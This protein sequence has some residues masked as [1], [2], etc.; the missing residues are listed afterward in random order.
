MRTI[1]INKITFNHIE[2]HDNENK[3]A[4][5]TVNKDK[6][7]NNNSKSSKNKSNKCDDMVTVIIMSINQQN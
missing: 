4:Y 1:L 5:D 2:Q 7:N 3:R 6:N